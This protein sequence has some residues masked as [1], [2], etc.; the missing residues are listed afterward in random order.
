MCQVNKT[1]FFNDMFLFNLESKSW[2]NVKYTDPSERID[3]VGNHCLAVVTDGDNFERMVM[4]GGINNF[5]CEE[6]SEVKSFLSNN[7]VLMQ[8]YKS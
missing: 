1:P 7:T 2:C 8:M 3:F 4:F 5:P 6:V